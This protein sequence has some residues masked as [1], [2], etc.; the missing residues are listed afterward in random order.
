VGAAASV[1]SLAPTP[2]LPQTKVAC[3]WWD[4]HN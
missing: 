1:T 2:A 3:G 4:K